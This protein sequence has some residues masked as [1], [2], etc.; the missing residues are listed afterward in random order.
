MLSELQL[1]LLFSNVQCAKSAANRGNYS[2]IINILHPNL[3]T[4]SLALHHHTHTTNGVASGIQSLADHS[5]KQRNPLILQ[6]HL[7]WT[8]TKTLSVTKPKSI[9]TQLPPFTLFSSSHE[10]QIPSY[11]NN[12]W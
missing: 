12:G 7:V 5:E 11:N 3:H 10:G 9:C 2:D 4:S 6:N 1:F 8:N